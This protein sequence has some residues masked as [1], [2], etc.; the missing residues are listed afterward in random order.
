MSKFT[1]GDWIKVSEPHTYWTGR[2]GQVTQIDHSLSLGINWIEVN[3]D[4]NEIIFEESQLMLF[5]KGPVD[6]RSVQET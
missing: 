6:L 3:L 5:E 2:V 4:G 1:V